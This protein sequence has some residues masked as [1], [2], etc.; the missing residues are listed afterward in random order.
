MK[1]LK[2]Q[3]V[4]QTKKKTKMG[5]AEFMCAENTKKNVERMATNIGGRLTYFASPEEIREFASLELLK[6]LTYI[7]IEMPF[8]ILR[9]TSKPPFRT[10]WYLAMNGIES[11]IEEDTTTSVSPTLIDSLLGWQS[12]IRE[13]G[14]VLGPYCVKQLLS[15]T[16][17][18]FRVYYPYHLLR[19]RT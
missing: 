11:A 16:E 13:A 12:H 14:R 7:V 19:N 4:F 2:H 5:F 6:D 15:F 1:H 18:A 17:Q 3:Q 9:F 10:R 8:G